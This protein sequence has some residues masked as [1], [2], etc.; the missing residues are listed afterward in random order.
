MSR[1]NKPEKRPIIPDAR[2]GSVQV[3][4]F[5]NR[6]MRNGKKSLAARLVYDALEIGRRSHQEKRAGSI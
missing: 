2:Y 1:R 6:V 3:Q 5:I 4:A